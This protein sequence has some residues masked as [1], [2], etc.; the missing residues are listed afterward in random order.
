M[1]PLLRRSTTKIKKK[2]SVIVF[3][4]SSQNLDSS[5]YVKVVNLKHS[6]E[7]DLITIGRGYTCILISDF[8]LFYSQEFKNDGFFYGMMVAFCDNQKKLYGIVDH[9]IGE[10]NDSI[11]KIVF[12]SIDLAKEWLI[13]N[14]L[15][16]KLKVKPGG[17]LYVNS[18][19]KFISECLNEDSELKAIYQ[20]FNHARNV[21]DNLPRDY[22]SSTIKTI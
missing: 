1:I 7:D 18:I 22:S 4:C 2:R 14:L 21:I 19:K 16:K 17:V 5:D 20:G 12:D 15:P 11:F 8:V 9:K 10:I 3:N 13:K 6:K